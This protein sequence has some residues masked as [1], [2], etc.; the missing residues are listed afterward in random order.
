MLGVAN[1]SKKSKYATWVIHSVYAFWL[2]TVLLTV[3]IFLNT[4]LKWQIDTVEVL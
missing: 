3:R 2:K 4:Y 1:Y